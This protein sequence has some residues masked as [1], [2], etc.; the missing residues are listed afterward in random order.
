MLQSLDGFHL[1]RR[2]T[3]VLGVRLARLVRRASKMQYTYLMLLKDHF[4]KLKII[5]R[6]I[7]PEKEIEEKNVNGSLELFKNVLL[8]VQKATIPYLTEKAMWI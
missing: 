4:T 7:R 3:N 2:G 1:S 6:R 8:D 5:T